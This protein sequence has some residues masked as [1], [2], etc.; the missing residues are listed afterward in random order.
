M[1]TGQILMT[2]AAMLL[3]GTVILGTNR[4]INETQYTLVRTNCQIDAVS[5]ATS[6]IQEASN[7]PFDQTTVGGA[8]PGIT[9][10][11]APDSLGQENNNPTDLDDLDDYNGLNNAGRLETD[12]LG[13]GT[14]FVRT[15]VSYVGDYSDLNVNSAT[16]TRLKRLDIWVWNKDLPDTLFMQA[17][18]GYWFFGRVGRI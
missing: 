8:A 15:K 17:V 6:M 18:F 7:L 2:I 4:G 10:F 5:L 12:V 16:R 14:Y 13:T 11:T 9:M 3:L 1:G